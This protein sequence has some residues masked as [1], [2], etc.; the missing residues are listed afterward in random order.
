MLFKH[1]KYKFKLNTKNFTNT[2]SRNFKMGHVEAQFRKLKSYVEVILDKNSLKDLNLS[3]L[4][5]FYLLLKANQ[6]LLEGDVIQQKDLEANI[7]SIINLNDSKEDNFKLTKFLFENFQMSKNNLIFQNLITNFFSIKPRD[8]DPDRSILDDFELYSYN[9]KTTDSTFLQTENSLFEKFIEIT[10]KLNEENN[11][12]GV[13]SSSIVNLFNIYP[14][15]GI[16]ITNNP[17]YTFHRDIIYD[18]VCSSNAIADIHIY[19]SFYEF[20]TRYRDIDTNLTFT[21][22]LKL[23]NQFKKHFYDIFSQYKSNE[24]ELLSI[25]IRYDSLIHIVQN[26]FSDPNFVILCEYMLNE[27]MKTCLCPLDI[28]ISHITFCVK[29]NSINRFLIHFTAFNCLEHLRS[30]INFQAFEDYMLLIYWFICSNARLL[31]D[32]QTL[33][34]FFE[35]F[36]FYVYENKTLKDS[37]KPI[38]LKIYNTIKFYHSH[39]QGTGYFD[40]SFVNYLDQT[41]QINKQL[42]II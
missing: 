12:K 14:N 24:S 13:N 40:N 16:N 6:D 1:I 29:E 20:Y 2:Y 37:T 34:D 42:N 36:Q 5:N 4:T 38:D 11:Y 19:H 25:P 31:E 23:K 26:N 8:I 22:N 9:F 3:D 10:K 41:I 35:E 18:L 33:K 17:L 15:L 7:T 30:K 21:Q 27:K 28:L 32:S 39:L